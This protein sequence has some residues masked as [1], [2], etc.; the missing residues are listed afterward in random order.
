MNKDVTLSEVGL[1]RGC[2]E[3][4]RLKQCRYGQYVRQGGL[5]IGVGLERDQT[6]SNEVACS[7]GKMK[8]EKSNPSPR[9]WGE[10]RVQEGRRRSSRRRVAFRLRR[11]TRHAS[12]RPTG[13]L[14]AGSEVAP[15]PP[16]A[17]ELEGH[18]EA[19]DV[20]ALSTLLTLCSVIGIVL[21]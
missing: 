13:T 15:P 2:L 12:F 11:V 21:L 4:G 7:K 20:S 5:N 14:H 19:S 8:E 3:R 1:E 9:W 10:G 18:R 17:L 6:T 16:D